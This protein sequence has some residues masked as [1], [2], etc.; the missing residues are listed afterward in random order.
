MRKSTCVKNSKRVT[1]ANHMGDSCMSDHIN[2]LPDHRSATAKVLR[3]GTRN[4]MSDNIH[5]YAS[6]SSDYSFSY[7]H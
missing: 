4:L 6:H 3:N 5:N 2:Y 7:V 1:H